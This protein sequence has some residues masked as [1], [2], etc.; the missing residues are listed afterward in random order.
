MNIIC[1][2]PNCR[3]TVFTDVERDVDS[4][5]ATEPFPRS[6]ASGAMMVAS[7]QVREL[8]WTAILIFSHRSTGLQCGHKTRP[9]ILIL[10]R[11]IL[12]DKHISNRRAV[13]ATIGVDEAVRHYTSPARRKCRCPMLWHWLRCGPFDRRTLPRVTCQVSRCDAGG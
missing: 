2:L 10:Y 4:A 8:S 5:G 9:S 1:L 13:H 6:G 3:M 7:Q 12:T 11:R